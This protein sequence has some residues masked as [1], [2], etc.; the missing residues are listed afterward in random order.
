M[1]REIFITIILTIFLTN[2]TATAQTSCKVLLPA[3]SGSYAG[4]C[5]LGLANGTGQATG[6]DF[7]K[8][9]F[10][11]GL[12]EGKGTYVWKNGGTYEGE[13]KKGMRDGRGLYTHTVENRDSILEGQWIEDKYVGK[14]ALAQYVIEYRNGIGRVSCI[15]TGDRPYVRYVFSRNGGESNNIS[16]LM[17]QGTSGSES[18]TPAFTGFEYVEFPFHGNVKFNA[19]NNFYSAIIT[20]ELRLTINHPG[21]WTVTIFY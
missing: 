17:L 18:L 16:S 15:R 19:P 7:Y 2:H 10:V 5:K 4:D 6:E 8:G 13:W 1:K 3:I 12:P 21:A 11:K 14:K 20:C 9:E